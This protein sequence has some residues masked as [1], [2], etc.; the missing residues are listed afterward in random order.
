MALPQNYNRVKILRCQRTNKTTISFK[1]YWAI[2]NGDIPLNKLL[3]TIQDKLNNTR[4]QYPATR[5]SLTAI[6]DALR[7]LEKA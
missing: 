5:A 6:L 3:P 2:V 1:C 7:A 4:P